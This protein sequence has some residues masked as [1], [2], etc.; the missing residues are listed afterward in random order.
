MED[1][2]SE[3]VAAHEGWGSD[4][5]AIEEGPSPAAAEARSVDA[6]PAVRA[7]AVEGDAAVS[8]R[9]ISTALIVTLLRA[10]LMQPE[11]TPADVQRA[12]D[13]VRGLMGS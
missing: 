3:S 4:V 11:R 2:I 12:L 7:Q 13:A 6:A 5:R 8:L 9:P 10:W 1:W